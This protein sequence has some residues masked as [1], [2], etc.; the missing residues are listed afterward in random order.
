[1]EFIGKLIL[2]SGDVYF[3]FFQDGMRQGYGEIIQQDGSFFL[4]FWNADKKVFFCVIVIVWAVAKVV[5]D[6][7]W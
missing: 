1:M 7:G 2:P 6:L 3:G 5:W 4:G